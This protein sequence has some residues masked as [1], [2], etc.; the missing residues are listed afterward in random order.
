MIPGEADPQVQ[1]LAERAR[2][3]DKQAQLDLGIRFEDGN[4]VP[5]DKARAMKLYRAA[6]SN[7]GGAMWVYMPSPG[8]DAKGGAF[9]LEVARRLMV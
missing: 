8:N 7:S 5:Q 6:A 4:G 1:A 3:G 2:G 9:R